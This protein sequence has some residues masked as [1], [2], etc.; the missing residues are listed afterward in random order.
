[1][2]ARTGTANNAP[3]AMK[4]PT[5]NSIYGMTWKPIMPS[6]F[7]GIQKSLRRPSPVA[8]RNSGCPE[9]GVA[10]S[11]PLRFEI[12]VRRAQTLRLLSHA[13]TSPSRS[14][15]RRMGTRNGKGR[16]PA[17]RSVY[18]FAPPA[19]LPSSADPHASDGLPASNARKVFV[20]SDPHRSHPFSL[21][22]LV[23]RAISWAPTRGTR[24]R[25]PLARHATRNPDPKPH[26]RASHGRSGNSRSCAQS[27]HRQ[28]VCLVSAKQSAIPCHIV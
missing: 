14:S 24:C 25:R 4:S 5:G 1:M 17:K 26:G 12:P 21:S 27:S 20:K 6:G 16:G 7:P 9:A 2:S 22:L 19:A 15:S 13:E 3:S 8:S 11:Q 18:L 10:V 28:S 23:E